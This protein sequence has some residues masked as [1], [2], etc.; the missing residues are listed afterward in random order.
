M[1]AIIWLRLFFLSFFIL[2]ITMSI[3]LIFMNYKYDVPYRLS[4]SI[5]Y[6]SKLNFLK[7]NNNLLK[8]SKTLVVG[9]SMALNN[10]DS[11]YLNEKFGETVNTASWGLKVGEVFQLIKLLDLSNIEYVIYPTQFIDFNDNRIKKI[12]EKEVK[13]YIYGN[14]S[15]YPLFVTLSTFLDNMEYFFNYKKLFRDKNE[16]AYLDFDKNGDINLE[17]D[18]SSFIDNYRWSVIDE[19]DIEETTFNTLIEMANYLN[20]KNIKLIVT[21]T[22]IRNTIVNDVLVKNIFS[23]YVNKLD[24]ISKQYNFTYINIHAILNLDDTYFVDKTHVNFQGAKIVS[25]NIK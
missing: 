17:F 12:N 10:I 9:S 15:F 16:Y 13:N 18:N 23:D 6:D 5:S 14:L 3:L 8:R 1:K 7:K 25:E 11:Y 24:V 20:S 2:F 22:P 21:T 19:H 4:N